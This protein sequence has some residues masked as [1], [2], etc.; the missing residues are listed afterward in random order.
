MIVYYQENRTLMAHRDG[1]NNMDAGA[2]V[3]QY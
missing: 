1:G 2:S 3:M